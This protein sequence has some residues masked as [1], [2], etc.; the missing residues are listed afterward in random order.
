MGRLVKEIVEEV[1]EFKYLRVWVDRKLRGNVQLEMTKMAEEWIGRVT[2]ISR[3]NGQVEV[4]RGRMVWEFL[5]R[6]CME[7]AAKV[8]WTG[9]HSACR[10][11]E[12]SPMIRVGDCWGQA[13]Q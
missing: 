6:P 3:V 4:E 8:W 1:E 10:K 9:G 13:I 12:S 5:A 2:W 7:Y 11:L